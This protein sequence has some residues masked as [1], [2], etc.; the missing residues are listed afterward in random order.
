LISE[1]E[2]TLQKI[3][4]FLKN[5]NIQLE[6]SAGSDN[7]I[8]IHEERIVV[9]RAQPSRDIIYTILHEIGH[10][11]SDFHPNEESKTTLVIEEVLAWDTGKDVAYS[12]SIDIDDEAWNKLMISSISKYMNC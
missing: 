6:Y 2:K 8:D 9:S 4:E 1:E 5:N 7:Y 10:Y 11:F 3:E 12:L